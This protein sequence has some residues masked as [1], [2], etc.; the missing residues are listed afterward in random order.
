M[1]ERYLYKL[2]RCSES[3]PENSGIGNGDDGD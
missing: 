1:E 2:I 3:W